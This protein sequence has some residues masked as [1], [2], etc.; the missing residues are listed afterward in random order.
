MLKSKKTVGTRETM[1]AAENSLCKAVFFAE[2]ANPEVL[3]PLKEVCV[4]NGIEMISVESM[5]L[6]GEC[7]GIKV[8]TASAGIV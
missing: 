1:R 5:K 6:L 7:C 8:P 3:K 4:K 2:D